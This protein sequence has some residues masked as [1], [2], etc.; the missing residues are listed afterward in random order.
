MCVW[1]WPTSQTGTADRR[2]CSLDTAP[3]PPGAARMVAFHLY[4]TLTLSCT[5][6]LEADGVGGTSGHSGRMV[7]DRVAVEVTGGGCGVLPTTPSPSS[8]P[9]GAIGACGGQP[10]PDNWL[11]VRWG[12]EGKGAGFGPACLGRLLRLLFPRCGARDFFSLG[13]WG[14]FLLFSPTN[15]HSNVNPN[16]QT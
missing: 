14:A 6:F 10:S 5:A 4:G 16:P 13:K 11:E 8:L 2:C 1:F 9:P 7:R 3:P 15:L 12:G